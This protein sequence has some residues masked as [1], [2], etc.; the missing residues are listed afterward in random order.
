MRRGDKVRIVDDF[1]T[2]RR[3]N[4]EDFETQIELLRGDLAELDFARR[5]V[6]GV[7]YVVH[8]A[9]IPSVPRSVADPLGNNR[10]G[11][12]ATLNL[13]LAAR[14][15]GVR[16]MTYASSSSIYGEARDGAAKREDM[17]PAPLSP[18]GVSKLASEQYCM[19][20]HTV[21][22]FEVVALRYFNVFGPRQDPRS[23]YA[24]VIPRFVTALLRG[25]QPTIYG[26]GEQTRDFTYVGNIVSANLHAL[27]HPNA[28]GQIFNIAMGGV[29]SLNQIIETLQQLTGVNIAPRYSD[30]R[31]GDI[32]H[33]L[34][35]VTKAV[36][37]MQF[38][39]QISVAEGLDA[40][41]AW[42]RARSAAASDSK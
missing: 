19:S 2:G 14:D 26:D 36:E 35:N 23:E 39:P 32:R 38:N 18:Y 3:E 41:I 15:A 17:L 42:Y 24:A 13:L 40:T 10:A 1:S 25:E 4:M 37:V 20:F 28:P 31:P 11:V 6:G 7:D 27:E 9:A 8:Q 30:P 21:Y 34:A 12:I 29:H 16:R 5:A 22:G 33:S